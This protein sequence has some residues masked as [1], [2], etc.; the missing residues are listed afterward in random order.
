M[1]N[2]VPRGEFEEL[3]RLIMAME[4]ELDRMSDHTFETR[5]A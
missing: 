1:S 5:E 4:G 3:R 2:Y